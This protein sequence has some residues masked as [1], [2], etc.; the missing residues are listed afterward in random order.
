MSVSVS[1]VFKMPCGLDLNLRSVRRAS[2]KRGMSFASFE[3][4]SIGSASVPLGTGLGTPHESY[5]ELS[6]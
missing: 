4:R 3:Y 1:P 6:N 5:L 2:D